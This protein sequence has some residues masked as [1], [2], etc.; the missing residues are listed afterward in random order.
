MVRKRC[1]SFH[2]FHFYSHIARYGASCLGCFAHFARFVRFAGHWLCTSR[3]VKH[4]VVVVVHA[5]HIIT[6][7]QS[8][9][10]ENLAHLNNRPKAI[11]K[12]PSIIDRITLGE[13][14]FRN[15]RPHP[16]GM[17]IWKCS[18]NANG[19]LAMEYI[20]EIPS[21]LM[22]ISLFSAFSQYQCVSVS[23][24][25]SVCIFI[26]GHAMLVLCK[27]TQYNTISL[28]LLTAQTWLRCF[29]PYIHIT[30]TL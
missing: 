26:S 16:R 22:R 5:I 23:V 10:K 12:W 21:S 15:V 17:M 2:L 1:E 13:H 24:C 4:V 9:I 7:E 6:D 8:H 18:R 27:S 25:V 11:K 29:L 20:N 3:G 19:R 28:L 30:H 14:W